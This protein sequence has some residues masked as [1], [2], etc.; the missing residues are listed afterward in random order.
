MKIPNR[1]S[2]PRGQSLIEA[3]IG[4][5]VLVAGVV[6]SLALGIITIR[7]GQVSESRTTADNLAREGIEFVRNLRD[8]NWLKDGTVW[9][10]GLCNPSGDETA[11]LAFEPT[12]FVWSLDRTVNDIDAAGA[13]L[14]RRDDSARLL[15]YF[16]QTS[17]AP[18]ADAQPTPFHRLITIHPN[19]NCQTGTATAY[20][21]T[22]LVTWVEQG[23]SHQSQLIETLTNWRL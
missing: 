19:A 15:T 23:K 2:A 21:V 14:Y 16:L 11:I 9:D 18:P 20:T 5:A 12:T 7:A 1:N 17:A 13:T 6:T 4:I 22:A 3:I 10:D 8:S